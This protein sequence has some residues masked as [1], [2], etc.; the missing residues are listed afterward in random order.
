MQMQ[1]QVG[2]Q[3]VTASLGPTQQPVVR[4]G[5]LA[6]VI[7]SE[8]HGQNYESVY[9][10]VL[11]GGAMQG[12]LATA[13][14]AGLGTAITG[15]S[16]LA[17]P[18]GSSVN[19]SLIN[20]GVAFVLAPAAPLAFGIATGQST[21]ALSGTLTSLAPKSKNLGSGVPPVGQ[22][23]ASAAITLPVAP[24]VD[25]VLGALDQGAVT[26]STVSAQG[27][28]QLNGSILIPPGGYAVFWTSAV[29]AA[30]AHIAS[31]TWEEVPV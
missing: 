5:Q 4:C 11:F 26:V 23:Y 15:T 27:F 17:N 2:P 9:R 7:V 6:D 10:K 24:T 22:L 8:L 19:L 29:L 31:W 20:F 13:T 30:S 16:V 21:T 18:N 14:I 1:G 28:Y 3:G 25:T 12:V